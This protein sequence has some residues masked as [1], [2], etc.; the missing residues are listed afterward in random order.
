MK[1]AVCIFSVALIIVVAG[2]DTRS[3]T[4]NTPCDKQFTAEVLDFKGSCSCRTGNEV[5]QVIEKIGL[6]GGQELQCKRQSLV[7]FRFCTSKREKTISAN[8]PDW[9]ILPNVPS[10]KSP[11]DPTIS[12]G[13][14]AH[15][16]VP[17][18][19]SLY[20]DHFR[21]QGGRVAPAGN[22]T[23]DPSQ[24]QFYAMIY[25][26][27]NSLDEGRYSEAASSFQKALR[28]SPSSASKA[29]YGL[30]NVYLAIGERKK[31]EEAYRQAIKT[32]SDSQDALI[33]LGFLL[34]QSG[35]NA[36]QAE[37]EQLARQAVATEPHDGR[38]WDLLGSVLE[39][40]GASPAEVEQSYRRAIQADPRYVFS[41]IHFGAFLSRNGKTDEAA[42]YFSK[43]VELTRGPQ[44]LILI[45]EEL[46]RLGRYGE[47]LMAAG[48]VLTLDRTNE[49]ALS[50]VTR[51]VFE[52]GEYEAAVEPLELAIK[53]NTKMLVVYEALSWAQIMLERPDRAEEVLD[54]ASLLVTTSAN[55]QAISEAIAGAGDAYLNRSQPENAVRMYQKALQ[56]D[57]GNTKVK[58]R[59]R[60]LSK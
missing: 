36:K 39:A 1:L 26:G 19:P 41:Y 5:K 45:G 25:E 11:Q 21:V 43:A 42:K 38:S 54:K 7:T 51:S 13:K 32:S 10:P 20:G 27:N 17:A 30:G 12:G 16:F 60:Q 14:T 58:D 55:R 40:H 50:L 28:L 29:L 3:Q 46:Q 33:A 4:I 9:Y 47:S 57:P 52:A 31:A 24:Q 15:L 6:Q 34:L 53:R 8:A 59:L 48:R 23:A 44:S 35:D 37:T 2:F 18:N 49:R 22:P 56:L